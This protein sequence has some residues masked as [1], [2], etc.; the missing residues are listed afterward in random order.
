MAPATVLLAAKV[1]TYWISI[2]LIGGV[3]LTGPFGWSGRSADLEEF[4]NDEVQHLL[5]GP[6][7]AEARKAGLAAIKGAAERHAANVLP[8]IRDIQKAGANTL[9]D[10]AEALNARG[11]ATA[12]GGQWHAMTVRNLL[13]RA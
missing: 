11:V 12:R 6:K 9:R 5:G 10:V 2:A 4:I 13:A 7:L 1:W 8:I 3:L